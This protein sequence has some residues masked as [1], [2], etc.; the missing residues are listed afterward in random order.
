MTPPMASA[1]LALAGGGLLIGG[2]VPF[3]RRRRGKDGA[4]ATAGEQEPR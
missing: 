3:G 2:L 1:A 4:D